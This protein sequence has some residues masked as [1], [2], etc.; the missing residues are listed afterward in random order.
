MRY[1]DLLGP[2]AWDAFPERDLHRHSRNAP[3][4][5]A[6]FLAACL[7]KLDLQ[8]PHMSQLR[9]YLIDHP[10][11]LWLLGFPLSPS[12]PHALGF[13]PAASLPTH[14]HFTRMLRQAPD[15]ALRFLLDSSVSLLAS[16]LA[17]HGLT[18][19]DTV[20]IDTKHILAWVKENNPKTYVTDRFHKDKQP[21]GDPDCR[22]GCKRRH[23]QLAAATH[24]PATP[25]HNPVPADTVAVGEFYWGYASGIVAAKVNGFG[26][27]VLAEL[28][29]PFDRADVS[30]FAPLLADVERRL[31]RPPRFGALDA[32]FDA[33]Y[34]YEYFHAA[35]GFAAIPWADRPDHKKRFDDQDRPL[36]PAGLPMPLHS[37]FLK[38]SHCLV[39]HQCA[40]Y[41]CPLF[42]P[43]SKSA[44]VQPASQSLTCPI[45]HKNWAKGGCITTLPTSPGARIRHQ[46]DRN[47]QAYKDLYRQRTATERINSQAVELGIERPKIRNGQA[48]AHL[49][50]L[51]YVLINLRAL[52]RIRQSAA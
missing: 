28:T 17:A 48:I 33:F 27:F 45:Q 38:T 10:P 13:D 6:P 52:Q 24:S 46:L 15:P 41:V 7:V 51:T 49:N 3:T 5:Y 34:I 14:R 8:L 2:L 37:A 20:A 11:L 9:Q 26:E 4:P 31:A 47:S 50:T 32:A 44:V 29:Q 21:P 40:R 25:K 36:C 12:T 23:N 19:G 22:L 30:Y 39:P 1:L 16:E 18:L 43:L 42:C 35:G